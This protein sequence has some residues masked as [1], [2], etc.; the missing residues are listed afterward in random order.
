[1]PA[2]YL[3]LSLLIFLL[4]LAFDGA[5]MSAGRHMPALQMLIYGPWGVPFGLYQWFANPLLAVAVL[6]HR[7]FRRLA[8]VLGLA[9]LYLAASSFAIDRLPD[10]RSYAFQD[11]IGFGAGFYLWLAA[12]GVFCVGQGWWCW[13]ARSASDMPGWRW[14]DVA[15]IAALGVAVYAATQM[16]SLRFQ[17]DKVLMPPEQPQAF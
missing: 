16:P 3:S 14:L 11:L 13:K 7:R 1:M 12:I 15:L 4:S 6:A 10:N 8:L 9:A 2:F 17:V 5:Q